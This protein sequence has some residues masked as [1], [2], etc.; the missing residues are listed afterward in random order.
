MFGPRSR[1]AV[2]ILACGAV[3]LAVTGAVWATHRPA[4]RV[5]NGLPIAEATGLCDGCTVNSGFIPDQ[6]V[7]EATWEQGL[8]PCDAGFHSTSPIRIY[9]R[10]VPDV[11][12]RVWTARTEEHVRKQGDEPAR[13]C[14]PGTVDTDQGPTF[15]PRTRNGNDVSVSFT[16]YLKCSAAVALQPELAGK[17]FDLYVAY[18]R[19]HLMVESWDTKTGAKVDGPHPLGVNET[20]TPNVIGVLA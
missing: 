13:R 8:F 19:Q 1:K 18:V 5:P 10:C 14:E 9:G 20:P 15:T 12:Y 3:V 11:T 16:L 2:S 17:T 7:T 6:I 4:D